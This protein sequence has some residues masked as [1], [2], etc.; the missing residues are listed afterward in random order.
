MCGDQEK[1]IPTVLN[2]LKL[3]PLAHAVNF[4]FIP[5]SQRILC[6][7]LLPLRPAWRS[8][9]LHRLDLMCAD[10]NTIAIGWTALLSVASSRQDTPTAPEVEVVVAGPGPVVNVLEAGEEPVTAS[11]MFLE[12][13]EPE[14]PP[15][16]PRP[17]LRRRAV[18]GVG[19]SARRVGSLVKFW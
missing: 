11:Q 5:P 14:V 4:A 9:G 6:E 18:S 13:A 10:I 7:S 2:S 3:W 8:P 19:S 1:L 15:P 17:S 16:A 12:Q